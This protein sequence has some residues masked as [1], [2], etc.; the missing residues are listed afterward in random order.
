M[1]S[2]APKDQHKQVK[3]RVE[4]WLCGRSFM[5]KNWARHHK[6]RTHKKSHARIGRKLRAVKRIAA[7]DQ[8]KLCVPVKV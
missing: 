7:D 5:A 3:E 2:T 8:G 6:S 1:A 4:C